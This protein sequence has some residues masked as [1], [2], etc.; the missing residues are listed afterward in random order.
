MHQWV[1]FIGVG[2]VSAAVM[3]SA[4]SSILSSSSMF[5]RNIYQAILFPRVIGILTT[6]RDQIYFWFFFFR[7]PRGMFWELC[8]SPSFSWLLWPPWWP[9]PFNPFT[10]YC[11]NM[12]TIIFQSHFSKNV[13]FFLY[14]QSVLSADLVYVLL[15]PQL[16]LVLYWN[17]YCNSYGC[18]A[19]FSLGI[20]CRVLGKNSKKLYKIEIE[21][22]VWIRRRTTDWA[23]GN[24]SL[25]ILR[26]KSRSIVSV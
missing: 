7:R 24:P 26:W 9:W 18:L 2:A 15:F 12:F 25:S 14:F 4:D 13:L 16:L 8:G 23:Q 11:N 21:K 6:N 19:S 5:A 20:I 10:D 17:E 1:S 3:S 22:I